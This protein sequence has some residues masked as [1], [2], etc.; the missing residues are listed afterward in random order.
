MGIRAI[1]RVQFFGIVKN[2]VPALVLLSFTLRTCPAMGET[3]DTSE[4]NQL[5]GKGFALHYTNPDSAINF[6]LRVISG[7]EKMRLSPDSLLLTDTGKEYLRFVITAYNRSGDIFYFEEEYFRAEDYYKH[8][9][10]L[11]EQAN[12]ADL[13]AKAWYDLGYCRYEIHDYANAATVFRTSLPLFRQSGNI[14]G[15][16]RAFN[17][18]G[19]ALYHL[20][21]YRLA[22]SSYNRALLLSDSLADTLLN[23]DIKIH[24]GILYCDQGKLEEGMLL[25][26]QALS[27]YEKSGN[28][29]AVSD[30][31]LNIGVVMK[32]VGEYDQA[33]ENILRATAIAESKQIKSQLVS[34]YYHLADLYLQTGNY[35]EALRYCRKTLTVA[36]E[37]PA[38][39]FYSEVNFLMGK[40][41]LITN[42][43]AEAIKYFSLAEQSAEKNQNI[44]LQVRIALWTAKA[45][46]QSG[47]CEKAI[48]LALTANQLAQRQHMIDQQKESAYIIYDCYRKKND[49]QQAL[50]WFE[51]Y[52]ALSDSVNLFEQQKEIRRIEA[53]YNYEKK[54][55]ENELLRNK[56][57][58]Q[59]QRLKNRTTT[60]IAFAMA[61][62]L[63]I[64]VIIQL[65]HRIKYNKA[66]SR[67]EQLMS[68]QQ[69]EKLNKEL[70]IK[71]RELTTKMMFLNQKNE[72]IN[73][74]IRQLRELQQDS[75]VNYRE[76]NE[77]VNELKVNSAEKNQWQEFETQFIEVHP[78]FFTKLYKK[79]PGLTAHEQRL[80]AFL[81]MNLSTKE[82]ASI[83]GRTPKSIEV[84]RSRIRKKLGLKRKDNLGSYLA[85]I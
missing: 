60:M 57:I 34:R 80:C 49:L 84:S 62:L 58:I 20:G 35:D 31:L 32:M 79:H 45:Y 7:Y 17:G 13:A 85:S 51:R 2:I 1:N 77:L 69:L 43:P 37:L 22:D 54:E 8:S 47:R 44:S 18:Y 30:A 53:R 68:L 75:D 40:Y 74:L 38:H 64:V 6:Y 12:F 76:I 65:I 36:E 56:S 61:V 10:Q 24:L 26:E 28:E 33:L 78:D 16:S 66:R 39:P 46:Q 48:S 67:E 42:N 21:K 25:F 41:Y 83:T 63:S 27:Y 70:D 82:I 11:A 4:V 71:K 5:L 23:S 9:L 72:L 50:F 59:E 3:P 15:L 29:Q 81:R 52:H 73:R 19:L 55:R 14:K